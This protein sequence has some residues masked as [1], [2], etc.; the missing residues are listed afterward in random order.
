MPAIDFS[1]VKSLDPIPDGSYSAEIVYA[2]EGTS[3]AGNPKIDLRW[4][5]IDGEFEGRLVFDVLTF[6][7][8]ALFRVKNTLK[9]LGWEDSFSGEVAAEDLIGRQATIVVSLQRN[10]E[11]DPATGE[12]YPDRNKVVKVKPLGLGISGLFA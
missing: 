5:V 7:P 6:T 1:E 2:E 10:T 8:A 4:K 12:A 3:K 9:A 11:S